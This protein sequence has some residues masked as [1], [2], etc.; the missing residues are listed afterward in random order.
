MQVVISPIG[1]I[2]GIDGRTFK[3]ES[4]VYET[5]KANKIDLPI[6]LDHTGPAIGWIKNSSLVLE[7]DQIL[8]LADFNKAG[9]AALKD[10]AYRYLS[11]TYLVDDD[12][13][14][15]TITGLG[16]VNK[17]NILK[18]ALNSLQGAY[19]NELP[20]ETENTENT[21]QDFS[22]KLEIEKFNTR[23]S[24]IET[25]LNEVLSAIKEL[26]EAK[27]TAEKAEED[28][29]EDTTLIEAHQSVLK[30]LEENNSV[31]PKRVPFLKKMC[32]ANVFPRFVELY[33]L[34]ANSL[35][36]TKKIKLDQKET[37][38]PLQQEINKQL[39]AFI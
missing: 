11:P 20:E 17:P 15:I 4:K 31:L 7:N 1:Q 32:G 37:P 8:G 33:Q 18:Q 35:Y 39:A 34:E 19:M 12:N 24:G 30:T 21:D 3:I 13:N 29:E 2:S 23:L 36:N 26:K 16:L 25:Q 9:Q 14:V 27:E 6:E 5:L 38:D 28:E 10:R 22:L